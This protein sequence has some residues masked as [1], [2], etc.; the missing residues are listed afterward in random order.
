[1]SHSAPASLWM[2]GFFL[3]LFVVILVGTILYAKKRS[4]DLAAAAQQIGFTFM[5]DAWHGP[6][7]NPQFKTCL[8]QRTRGRPRKDEQSTQAPRDPQERIRKRN[9]A[10]GPDATPLDPRASTTLSIP[11]HE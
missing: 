6:V 9:G 3:T 11:I 10:A 1:M 2:F 4:Q 8:L 7:L 5:G